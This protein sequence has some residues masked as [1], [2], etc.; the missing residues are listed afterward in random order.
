MEDGDKE[1]IDLWREFR[2]ISIEKY[3]KSYARLNIVFDEYA[4]E[5]QVRS[6]SMISAE[7][8]LKEKGISEF[9]EGATIIDFK[10]YGAKTLEVAVIRN[11]NGTSNYLLRDIGA[12]IQR[13]E[14]HHFDKSVYVIMDEQASHVKRLFKIMELL[15][16]PYDDV[17]RRMEFVPFGKVAGMSSRKGNVK[18][19]DDILDECRT[20]M[21][22]TMRKNDEK[23][24]QVANPEIT[25]DQL[26]ISACVVQDMSS[27]RQTGYKF[28]I[29]RMTSFE[30]DTGPYLQYAHARLCSIARNSGYSNEELYKADFSLLKEQHAVDL[31]RLMGQ[32]PDQ[33]GQALG[34]LEPSTI[35][36]YLFKLT[37]QLS[38]GYDT[39]RVVNASE[40]PEVSKARAA[41]YLGARQVIANGL[42]LIG[43]DPIERYGGCSKCLLSWC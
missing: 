12:A 22:D 31:V 30:G 29:E 40:G 43:L 14:E 11:R 35:I 20:V 27:K 42:R 25:A 38:S 6:E 26:G 2:S 19:L 17:A 23:Y 21:H 36:T 3:K 16:S 41:L 7:K 5:S 39:L 28:V 4:G 13:W 15:G 9:D 1:A 24:A 33:I 18:F 10:K 34:N 8:I 32:Y 37:H